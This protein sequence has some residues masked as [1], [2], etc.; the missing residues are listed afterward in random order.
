VTK[1][2]TPKLIKRLKQ[3][4]KGQQI[5]LQGVNC[6]HMTLQIMK[7]NEISQKLDLI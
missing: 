2:P 1:A 3:Q 6:N 7:L 5:A 4:F